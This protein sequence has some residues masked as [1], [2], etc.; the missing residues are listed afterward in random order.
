[1]Q[2][3]GEPRSF[4]QSLLEVNRAVAFWDVMKTPLIGVVQDD[5]ERVC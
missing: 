2:T 3:R 4:G 1:M 5:T